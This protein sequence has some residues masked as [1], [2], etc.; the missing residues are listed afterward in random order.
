MNKVKTEMKSFHKSDDLGRNTLKRPNSKY[1]P[2]TYYSDKHF[3]KLSALVSGA[4]CIWLTGL[5]IQRVLDYKRSQHIEIYSDNHESSNVSVFPDVEEGNKAL[6]IRNL[7]NKYYQAFKTEFDSQLQLDANKKLKNYISNSRH[8]FE[9]SE[10][11]VDTIMGLDTDTLTQQQIHDL[12][13]H[14][15]SAMSSVITP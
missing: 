11:D 2:T 7:K 13:K 3:W 9:F 1:T 6:D 5:Y 4:A 8:E 14:K 15:I 12:I 10:S